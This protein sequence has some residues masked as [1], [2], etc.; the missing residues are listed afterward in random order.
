M[1]ATTEPAFIDDLP[2]LDAIIAHEASE[3]GWRGLTAHGEIFE[4]KGR[5]GHKA[6]AP[7]GESI[8]V[9]RDGKAVGRRAV[10][11]DGGIK[12]DDY[13]AR[14]NRGVEL[15]KAND[16]AAAL[17]QFD[18]AIAIADTARAQFNR[19][20]V[21]LSL[22]H[23]RE[24]LEGH[25]KRL[26]LNMP[27]TCEAAAQK[28]PLWQGEDLG[29]KTLLLVHDAGFGDSIMLLRYVP[30]LKTIGA[31]VRL[32]MPPELARLAEQTAPLGDTGDYFCP[33]LSLLHRL[34][35]SIEIIP[36]KPYLKTDPVLVEQW[37]KRISQSWGRRRIGIA[38]SV[39]RLVVGDYPRSIPLAAL[40]EDLSSDADLYSIQ[41]QEREVAEE[42]GVKTFDLEDFADCAALISLMDEIVSIDTAAVHVAG[43]IGHPNTTVLLGNGWA[44]WRWHENPFYPQIRIRRHDCVVQSVPEL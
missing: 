28:M 11:N 12:I 9:M 29:G 42:L 2:E 41:K 30:M 34:G 8:L 39:G 24:G 32:M 5:N 17:A 26:A 15:Y 10:S 36:N 35:Q 22:G 23:W 43:A 16:C 33:M 14:H 3:N 1:R 40:V 44:S 13:L 31:N 7:D 37:R 6:I 4:V 18:A 25:E 27:Y 19:G 21:L 20:L 38:W